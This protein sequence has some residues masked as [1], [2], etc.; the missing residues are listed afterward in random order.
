MIRFAVS[1]LVWL[2]IASTALAQGSTGINRKV[3]AKADSSIPGFEAIVA[4]VE[5]SAGSVAGRHT[6]NGDEIGY[7][8]EGGGE[9]LID[10]ETPRV[11][12]AGDAFII[13]AGRVHDARTGTGI[14]LISTYV[15]EKGK[16][17]ASSG[18]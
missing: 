13:P 4:R 16:P 2:N 18:K 7:V 14:Q 8:M 11:L 6:H 5:L 17:L 9:L 3:V 12:K 1:S 10:G 15:V